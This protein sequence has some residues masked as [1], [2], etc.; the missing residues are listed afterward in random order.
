MTEMITIFDFDHNSRRLRQVRQRVREQPTG[1][2]QHRAGLLFRHLL[3]RRM[4]LPEFHDR[5][6]QGSLQVRKILLY[7]TLMGL[8]YISLRKIPNSRISLDIY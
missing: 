4:E 6:T 7:F 5:G 3:L 1:A 8:R 2:R